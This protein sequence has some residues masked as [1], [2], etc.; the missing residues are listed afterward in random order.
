MKSSMSFGAFPIG[1]PCA[2]G[3]HTP[4]T[5]CS[6]SRHDNGETAHKPV[7]SPGPERRLG[8]RGFVNPLTN[9]PFRPNATVGLTVCHASQH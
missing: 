5:S 3:A 8:E 1:T 6:N 4:V 7:A 2:V 9:A